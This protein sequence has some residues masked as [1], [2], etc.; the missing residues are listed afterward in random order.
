MR[1]NIKVI[2]KSSLNKIIK[3]SDTE[4]KVKLTSP[5]VDGEANKKLIEILSKEYKVAKSK[6]KIVKGETSKNKVVEIEV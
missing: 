4:L 2:P 1:L 3:L 5:P 6:I